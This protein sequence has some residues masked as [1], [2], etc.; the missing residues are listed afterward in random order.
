MADPLSRI[1]DEFARRLGLASLPR[2]PGG[3]VEFTVERAGTV[4]IE[5]VRGGVGVTLA[6]RR[7]PHAEG[8]ARAAL[9]LCHWRENHPWPIHAGMKGTEW[10]TLTAAIPAGEFAPPVLERALAV[11]SNLQDALEGTG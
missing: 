9:A 4:H 5:P 8:A 6:R 3:A 2:G 1:L 7:P 11:L 10:L